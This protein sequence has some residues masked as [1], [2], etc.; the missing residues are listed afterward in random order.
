MEIIS[1]FAPSPT[2]FL[3]V[4]NIRTAILNYMISRSKNGKFILRIDDTDNT[5][6]KKEFVDE[7]KYDLEWLGIEWDQIVHQS[8]RLDLYSSLANFLKKNGRLYECFE[9]KEELDLKRKK[10]LNSGKPPIYDRASLYMTENKKNDLRHNRKSYW[11]FL[12]N[13]ERIEWK[14]EI[15][16]KTSIDTA[17]LSD[18]V[19]IRADGQF[20]YTLASVKDDVDFSISNVIRGLDH[21]TNTAVQ[22]Q[23][24]KTFS[25]EIP[26]FAHHSL[27][28]GSKGEQLSKRIGSLS[29]K[30]LREEGIEPKAIISFLSSLGSS[31]ST[32]KLFE[33]VEILDNFSLNTFGSAPTKFDKQILSNL[34]VK[35][36]S[37]IN[38][39]TVEELIELQIPENVRK[40]FWEMAKEN[41][42]TRK[43]LVKL[44]DLCKNGTTP[45]IK[46]EDIEF[47]KIC[48][49]FIP[50]KPRDENSWINWINQ[51][52]I[53]TGRQGK[54]IYMPLRKALTGLESGPDMKKLFPLLQKV[55]KFK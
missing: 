52:K 25:N 48:F 34:S 9:T 12:L 31:R 10:L 3:H 6:S 21:V 15:I 36:F 27:L 4:G 44:W 49:S 7:I 1:R 11:R 35:T 37:S 47:I 55:P 29:V 22:I 50:E 26:S 43:E 2:G 16:G 33:K 24:M 19:L 41:I 5:R 51:I 17:S 13:H 30:E 40:Q 20:L 18:P 32:S 54:N 14:D 23:I 46:K 38:Y 39:D 8:A 28:T 45:V 53:K 42:K